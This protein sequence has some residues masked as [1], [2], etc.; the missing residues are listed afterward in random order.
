MLLNSFAQKVA[1]LLF[2][3]TFSAYLLSEGQDA[4]K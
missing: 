1:W 3:Q 2:L 4:F